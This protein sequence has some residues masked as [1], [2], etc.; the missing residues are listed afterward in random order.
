MHAFRLEYKLYCTE[1]VGLY[2]PARMHLLSGGVGV[3]REGL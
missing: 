2:E 1:T 3:K